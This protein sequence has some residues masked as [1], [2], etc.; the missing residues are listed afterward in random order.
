MYTYEPSDT[1]M[2]FTVSLI[3]GL[4]TQSP[5]GFD[6]SSA[7]FSVAHIKLMGSASVDPYM[8]ANFL[9]CT[10]LA[11]KRTVL[12]HKRTKDRQKSTTIKN[13]INNN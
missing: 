6:S 8:I 11:I 4:P 1:G 5:S 10:V 9:S 13:L 12:L 2:T 3:A 7:I